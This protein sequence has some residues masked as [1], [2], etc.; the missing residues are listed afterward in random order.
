[1]PFSY[2]EFDLSG[3]KTYPLKSRAS[4]ACAEDSAGRTK[5]V[6]ASGRSSTR[7][8]TSSVLAAA[9]RLDVPVSV[10]VAIGTD[11]THMHPA[12]S[13]AAIG[14]GSLR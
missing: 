10:H 2:D 3:V 14:E 1:M 11:V 8:R 6:R 9:A 7:C 5:R 4:K 12:A 13:G